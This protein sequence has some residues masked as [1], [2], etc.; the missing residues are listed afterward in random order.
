MHFKG[1]MALFFFGFC[2]S[3]NA[4]TS[5]L[6]S[7]DAFYHAFNAQKNHVLLDIRTPTEYSRG[8]IAQA[9]NVDYYDETFRQKILDIDTTQTLFVYCQSG[10]RSADAV[11]WMRAQGFSSV[12]EL[13][14]GYI[15]WKKSNLPVHERITSTDK[16][17]RK[18]F[19]SVV[20]SGKVLVDFYAPWCGPCKKMEPYLKEIE[21]NY[22][23]QVKVLRIN[24][25]ENENLS[26]ELHVESIP[27][28]Q[29]Y[30]D[31]KKIWEHDS[32]ISRNKLFKALDIQ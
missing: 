16:L 32:Y 9:V 15:G 31:G 4:Q 12:F 2:S 6:L 13:K 10:G 29:M 3:L 28:L 26:N 5:P 20:S 1:L 7:P 19:N 18:E 17:S 21:A 24:V 30:Q 27:F 8:F 22:G 14:G 11:A 25:D 23:D